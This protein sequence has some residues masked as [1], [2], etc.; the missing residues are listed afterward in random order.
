MER[1]KMADKKT[2]QIGDMVDIVNRRKPVRCVVVD[3]E[4]NRRGAWE[5]LLREPG[6]QTFKGK[7]P[8]LDYR[9][10][11]NIRYIGKTSEKNLNNTREEVVKEHGE[12]MQKQHDFIQTGLDK[13]RDLGVEV[14][15]EVLYKYRNVTRA[16]TVLGINL[17]KGKISVSS[18]GHRG[19]RWVWAQGIVKILKKASSVFK[20]E[21]KL[22]VKLSPST[23]SEA[24]SKGWVQVT[25]GSEF[26]E[27][28]YVV[29]LT[30]EVVRNNGKDYDTAS[31]NVYVDDDLGLFWR[32]TGSFD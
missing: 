19:Y 3:V 6:G 17:R 31:K 16:E 28:S 5:I 15:D 24:M 22:P 25:F 7:I 12:T 26:I 9:T 23:V 20:G 2:V 11:H 29:G 30:P 8:S 18:S 4:M 10:L 1:R 21:K 27:Q 13:I 14:G 32:W